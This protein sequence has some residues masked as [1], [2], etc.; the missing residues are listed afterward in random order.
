MLLRGRGKEETF[1]RSQ[2][3]CRRGKGSRREEKGGKKEDAALSREGGGEGLA[4]PRGEGARKTYAS[5]PCLVRFSESER[6]SCS[7]RRRAGLIVLEKTE[8]GCERR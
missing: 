2:K 6:E 8:E 3:D 1:H 4:H 7:M 5:E